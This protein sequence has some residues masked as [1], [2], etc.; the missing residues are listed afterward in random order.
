MLFV[1]RV[2]GIRVAWLPKSLLKI[3]VGK[4]TTDIEQVKLTV[5]T[6]ADAWL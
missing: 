5:L 4:G 6:A 1:F 3:Y 2:V